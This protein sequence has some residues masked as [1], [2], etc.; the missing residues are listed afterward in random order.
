MA[1]GGGD[2]EPRNSTCPA[3]VRVC[4]GVGYLVVVVGTPTCSPSEHGLSWLCWVQ[5]RRAVAKAAASSKKREA[6]KSGVAAKAAAMSAAAAA[7]AVGQKLQLQNPHRKS[8]SRPTVAVAA[9]AV[10]MDTAMA[11]PAKEYESADDDVD[12]DVVVPR[13]PDQHQHDVRGKASSDECDPD[14]EMS[15]ETVDRQPWTGAGGG[16][17]VDSDTESL[18]SFL[19]ETLSESGDTDTDWSSSSFTD[20]QYESEYDS[21]CDAAAAAGPG[22]APDFEFA[23]MSLDPPALPTV[24]SDRQVSR[25]PSE[26][27]AMMAEL[28]GLKNDYTAVHSKLD[29]LASNLESSTRSRLV[30][31][32][33]GI[34][35][36]A[37]AA[38]RGSGCRTPT[39]AE[40]TV[41]LPQWAAD[42]PL[43]VDLKTGFQS[44]SSK[45][46]AWFPKEVC[47]VTDD[48][49][50]DGARPGGRHPDSPRPDPISIAMS[51]RS[52]MSDTVFD[53]V[54]PL[55]H[56]A[57]HHHSV[58]YD[59]YTTAII[60]AN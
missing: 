35:A 40:P 43:F 10:E 20:T 18:S 26:L 48:D 4:V 52:L 41:V 12:T 14:D 3:R 7:A 45:M 59:H 23:A 11:G 13:Q 53:F 38:A 39:P 17:P 24:D 58:A 46:D 50:H 51:P 5:A 36:V 37:A 49:D 2:T 60:G 1:V 15:W 47:S 28:A 19:S 8:P 16:G 21:A 33:V 27:E 42:D 22:P 55:E 44:L 57:A 54:T 56:D 34:P 6:R 32:S 29:E 31:G 9:A 25:Q 30:D